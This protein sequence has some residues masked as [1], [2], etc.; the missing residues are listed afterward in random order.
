MAA[1]GQHGN[2]NQQGPADEQHSSDPL[3]PAES[4]QWMQG[5]PPS[6]GKLIRFAD[7][8]DLKY[9]AHRWLYSHWRELV[10]TTAVWRGHQASAALPEALADLDDFAFDDPSGGRCTLAQAL[11][12]SATDGLLILQDGKVLFER[13]AGE[14]HPERQHRCFSVTKSFVGLMATQLIHQGGLDPEASVISYLPELSASGWSNASVSQVLDMVLNL[15][16][17]ENYENP[18]S[19]A[20]KARLANGSLPRPA[21]YRGPTSICEY[22][23]SVKAGGPHDQ[24]FSYITP[25]TNV[26]AWI[27]Q[28][29]TGKPLAT[30]LS[31]MIWQKIGAEQV[32]YFS[33]DELGMADAGGGL[34]VTLRDLTRFG[35][36]I[37]NGG[38]AQ[39]QQVIDPAVVADICRGADRDKFRHAGYT[40]FDGW[41]Y[42]NQWWISHDRH[43]AIRA[44]GIYGQQLYIAP[45]AALVIARFGSQRV[46]VD[47]RIEKLLMSA[48][49]ALAAAAREGDLH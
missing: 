2:F 29:V 21:G 25:N 28:R 14:L 4:D 3:S 13:Y 12:L 27:L 18:E 9:P 16:F 37:R 20:A 10:P 48:F 47:E 36:M 22:L 31:E 43:D 26:L 32:G 11:E 15:A 24:G 35:E 30:L 33:I 7:L 5:F 38:R 45:K 8:P 41:S 46:A 17:D 34:C 40:M 49:E 42:H 39:G 44:L 6:Q 1:I 19:D 23:Q